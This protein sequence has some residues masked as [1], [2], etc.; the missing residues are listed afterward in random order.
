LRKDAMMIYLMLGIWFLLTLLTGMGLYR[1]WS[2]KMGGRAVDW[3]LLPGTL[4]SELFFLIGRKVTRT[5]ANTGILAPKGNTD[6]SAHDATRTS[7]GLLVDMFCSL[8]AIGVCGTALAMSV[9]H[10][11]GQW[12]LC[13]IATIHFFGHLSLTELPRSM[14]TTGGA[15]WE[16]LEYQIVII[17]RTLYAWTQADWS[18]WKTPLLLYLLIAFSIRLGPVRHDPRASMLVAILLVGIT[19]AVSAMSDSV[20]YMVGHNVWWVLTGV[21]GMLMTLLAVTLLAMAIATLI[22]LFVRPK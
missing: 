10:L 20:D 9:L 2:A 14:P 1:L 21:W 17:R 12:I 3:L 5:P 16:T 15:F 4:C 11:G 19:A 18:I 6:G 13:D 22:R 8:L 7:S